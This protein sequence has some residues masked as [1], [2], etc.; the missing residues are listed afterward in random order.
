MWL[1]ASRTTMLSSAKGM[2]YDCNRV[3]LSFSGS[4]RV[5]LIVILFSAISIPLVGPCLRLDIC[6]VDRTVFE[7]RGGAVGV[8][9]QRVLQPFRVI[10]LGEITTRMRAPRLLA[11]KGR[12]RNRLRD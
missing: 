8:K 6:D 10:A 3:V 12:V 11:R 2:S 1:S 9:C 7:L 5:V 4:K